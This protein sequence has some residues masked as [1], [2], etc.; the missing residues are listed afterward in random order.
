MMR[1]REP[2]YAELGL[3]DASTD[4]LLDAMS[5]YP[6]LIERPIAIRGGRLVVIGY[7]APIVS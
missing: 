2:R 7:L 4:E 3:A 6:E 1:T 5:Q